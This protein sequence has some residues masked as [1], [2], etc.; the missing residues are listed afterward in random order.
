MRR[1]PSISV[2]LHAVIGVLTVA[3]VI[4]FALYAMRA[5]G[6][7]R[8]AERLPA[9]VDISNDLFAAVQAF[10]LERGTV[11]HALD[12]VG[13]LDSTDAT[14]IADERAKADKALDSALAKLPPIG[15]SG[16][17][18]LLREISESRNLY[19]ALRGEIGAILDG[20]KPRSDKFSTD[21]IVINTRLVRAIENLSSRLDNEFNEV[22]PFIAK[23]MDVKR[24]AGS[25]R[26]DT[27]QD[28]QLVAR[29]LLEGARLSDAQ[30]RE[31]TVVRGRVDGK[32]EIIKDESRL[33]STPA[34]LKAEIA[35]HER[36][37]E[38]LRRELRRQEERRKRLVAQ[39]Q[40]ATAEKFDLDPLRRR[41][42]QTL[43]ETRDLQG[44]LE[45]DKQE[46]RVLFTLPRGSNKEGWV[47]VVESDKITV[48]PLGRAAKPQV[49]VTTGVI[50]KTTGADA[51]A[52]WIVR[53][54]LRSAYFLVLIRP[55]GSRT[56]DTLE[57]ALRGKSVSFGF[58]LIDAERSVLHPE[59]GAAP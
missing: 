23:M 35:R 38:D 44:Q 4:I 3:L 31:F 15:L 37:I 12:I 6:N 54:Q 48:A 10:R 33:P 50:L 56:F 53:N 17:Q 41:L 52:D 26:V 28:R 24:I 1:F 16:S 11:T 51:L 45:Q 36:T 13:H 21:W 42:E 2:L 20:R 9:I 22:D 43:Q 18:P 32:W 14:E 57:E 27:G 55:N 30:H 46:N 29:A 34:E 5:L 40:A 7:E 59:R 47:A 8:E 25:L 49:F 39:Q 19:V 58:D